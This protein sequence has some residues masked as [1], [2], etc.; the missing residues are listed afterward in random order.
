MALISDILNGEG[1]LS[2][3]NKLNAFIK[4]YN[5]IITSDSSFNVL[6]IDASYVKDATP[7]TLKFLRDDGTWQTIILNLNLQQIL[8]NG[9]NT[10]ALYT[11]EFEN[12]PVLVNETQAR[13]MTVNHAQQLVASSVAMNN[14][15]LK[16]NKGVAN[17]YASLDN[18]GLVPAAQLPS[19]ID[20]VLEFANLASFPIT[21]ESGKIYV[22]IDTT[23]QYRWGGS[24]Y[25]QISDGKA[26]WGGVD[27]LLSNQ[28]D[29][30][31]ALNLK[32]DLSNKGV[33][34]GYASL[35]VTGKVPV[36]QMNLPPANQLFNYYNFL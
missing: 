21:G 25:L 18:S 22:A 1:G 10:G 3:R 27:G 13:V 36:T 12:P 15:E 9:E 16:S 29:L 26:T 33:A 30:Q 24:S 4:A 6:R 31:G 5:S 17:G 11:I 20:D 2:V 34:N 7:T 23:K 28:T 14:I 35:D 19:F 32:E 8:A